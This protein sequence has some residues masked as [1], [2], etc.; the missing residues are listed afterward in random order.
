M[1]IESTECP[2]CGKKISA[3]ARSCKC[4]WEKKNT[5]GQKKSDPHCEFMADG[6]RCS[7]PGSCS[8]NVREGG[9][10]YCQ[11][12]FSTI[13]DFEVGKKWMKFISEKFHEI[14]HFRSHYQANLKNCE[15]CKS[16]CDAENDFRGQ[17]ENRSGDVF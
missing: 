13:G 3:N 9:P 11:Y 2:D 5:F 8:P 14:I 1:F 6:K 17:I 4:G 15:K 10:W 16:L 12:H 7:L